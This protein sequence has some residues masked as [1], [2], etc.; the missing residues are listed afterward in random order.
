M[1]AR[2][3]AY[4]GH[5]VVELLARAS[6]KDEVTT[7]LDRPGSF[8]QVVHDTARNLGVSADALALLKTLQPS[9][10]AVSDVTWFRTDDGKAS[11][12]WL[13]GVNR[14]MDP[15]ETESARGFAL[16]EHVVIANDVPEGAK[17]YLDGESN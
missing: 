10:D 16:L 3:T 5:L 15:Q 11:F 4:K 6:I 8:G 2:I 7:S 1:H 13:G 17:D 9:G 12:G 14:L